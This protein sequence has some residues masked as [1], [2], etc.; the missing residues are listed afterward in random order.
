MPP[1]SH[2][3]IC[4]WNYNHFSKYG[5]Q[6]IS[7]LSLFPDRREPVT[8]EITSLLQPPARLLF[9]KHVFSVISGCN[10]HRILCHGN[11]LVFVFDSM[12]ISVS[13]RTRSK[14]KH[15][16]FPK[17]ALVLRVCSTIL[18]KT[19]W[20]KEKL[21]VT[22]NFS[23]SHSVF[24]Q[25]REISA[26][27]NRYEIAI[28]KLFWVW[29]SLKFV[30]WERVEKITTAQY[31]FHLFFLAISTTKHGNITDENKLCL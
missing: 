31:S 7:L 10:L 6:V 24:Y 12:E 4:L 11:F 26:F 13:F 21:L 5:H 19:L 25:L 17:Q 3:Q 22:S 2:L 15:K 14:Y 30:V 28:C 16:P 27:F 8:N 18:L 29:K 1:T 9:H 23:F 20:E